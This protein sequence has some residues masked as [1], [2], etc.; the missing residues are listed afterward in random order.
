MP[1]DRARV[2]PGDRRAYLSDAFRQRCRRWIDCRI[3]VLFLQQRIRGD[4]LPNGTAVGE[5]DGGFFVNP[6]SLGLLDNLVRAA[7]SASVADSRG[8]DVERPTGSGGRLHFGMAAGL[9]RNSQAFAWRRWPHVVSA[10]P[11]APHAGAPRGRGS[12]HPQSTGVSS[13]P[14]AAA[15]HARAWAPSII[16]IIQSTRGLASSAPR[17][18]T[19]P[20]RSDRLA[21]MRVLLI[22]D[23]PPNVRGNGTP[24]QCRKR[25]LDG[26]RESGRP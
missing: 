3:G 9:H 4:A 15:P 10:A 21:R 6:R 25:T 24:F 26:A 14:V 23:R 1:A 2:R 19:G 13:T 17:W 11:V 12:G 22:G 18:R 7:G 16:Q 8:A 20:N 5:R